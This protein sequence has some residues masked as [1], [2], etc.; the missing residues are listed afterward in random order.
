MSRDLDY[1]ELSSIGIDTNGLGLSDLISTGL[2]VRKE[3]RK[4]EREYGRI[5][6]REGRHAL[7]S[8][9]LY[10]CTLSWCYR[11]LT[12]TL[13]LRGF[14]CIS[15]HFAHDVVDRF[16][17][18]HLL[19]TARRINGTE[20]YWTNCCL[21]QGRNQR[22]LS[23]ISHESSKS[24]CNPSLDHFISYIFHH[25]TINMAFKVEVE[26]PRSPAL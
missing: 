13:P 6:T 1:S 22:S 9:I 5:I 15:A 2:S 26:D 21:S 25:G 8:V 4:T 3:K 10:Y 7:C 18:G 16:P 17:V 12:G 23:S 14:W 24:T 19:F 11:H 20:K